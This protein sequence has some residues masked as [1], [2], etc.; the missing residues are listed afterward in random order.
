MKATAAKCLTMLQ[1]GIITVIFPTHA[2]QF[3]LSGDSLADKEY[4]QWEQSEQGVS[5]QA[6]RFNQDTWQSNRGKDSNE[7]FIFGQPVHAMREGKVVSCW[8]K[9]P[10]NDT[11]GEY[12]EELGLETPEADTRI[13]RYGNHLLIEHQDGS[14]ALYAH[15]Q[16]ESIPQR[17][18]PQ[19]ERYLMAVADPEHADVERQ[20]RVM[21]SQQATVKVGEKLGRVGNSGMSKFPQLFLRLEKE[22][23]LQ[24][25]VFEKGLFSMRAQKDSFLKWQPI[26]NQAIPMPQ[27]FFWPVRSSV[28][29]LTYF[30]QSLNDFSR[31]SLWLRESGYTPTQRDVYTVGGKTFVNV[32]WQPSTMPWQSYP[33]LNEQQHLETM[34]QA[35]IDGYSLKEIDTTLVSG[36]L[37]YSTYYVQDLAPVMTKHA[38]SLADFNTF[39]YE[40]RKANMGAAAISVQYQGEDPIITALFRPDVSQQQ[41]YNPRINRDN[42]ERVYEQMAYKKYYPVYMNAYYSEQLGDMVSVIFAPRFNTDMD[43][44]DMSLS[45]VKS[46][47]QDA[48]EDGFKQG[49]ISGFDNVK[50]EHRFVGFWLK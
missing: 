29:E 5:L 30:Q 20:T 32:N 10:D 18:C 24:P 33:L 37:K 26:E 21:T 50:D 45:D 3:P 25:L 13:P 39:R 19:S 35:F 41:E 48:K 11:I 47:S 12:D 49:M 31:L 15:M 38:M 28:K 4:L 9:A 14:R 36:E 1:L 7:A 46:A 2:D 22:D 17:L 43:D 23:Q 40:A 6:V 44:I 42:F 34:N 8:R 27:A 16:Q